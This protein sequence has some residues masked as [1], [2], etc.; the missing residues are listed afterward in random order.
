[1][2]LRFCRICAGVGLLSACVSTESRLTGVWYN[3]AL[4]PSSVIV[5]TIIIE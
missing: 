3:G 4:S 2:D 1:M 5:S